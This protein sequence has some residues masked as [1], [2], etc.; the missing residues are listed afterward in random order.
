M[1]LIV[2]IGS[3]KKTMGEMTTGEEEV[4]FIAE[5]VMDADKLDTFHPGWGAKGAALAAEAGDTEPHKVKFAVIRVEEGWSGSKR[6]WDGNELDSIVAQT[7]ALEPVGHLGHIPD[8]QAAFSMPEPQT[9][10]FGAT[11]KTEPSKQKDRMGEMVK[12]AYFAGYNLL[13]ARVRTLIPSRAVRGISWWGKGEQVVI[14]GKGVQVKGFKLLA[15][16]WARK[17]SE[18]MPTSSVVATVR[19]MEDDK[20]DKALSQVTPEEFEKENP[21]GYALLVAKVTADK[22]AKIGEM[23]TKVAEGETAKTLLAKACEMLGIDKPEDIETK[24]T[25][26]RSRVG[27]KAKA[28]LKAGLDAILLEKLPGAENA[29]KRALVAR[30]LPVGE[31]ETKVADTADQA[32]ADKLIGEMVDASIDKDDQIKVVI[33]EQQPPAIRRR[34]ELRGS[35]DEDLKGAGVKRE[36]V[37]L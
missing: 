37:R 33:G 15:L 16:D 1:G 24:I 9:T 17:G 11:V 35:T 28:T 20:M 26:L 34:E 10:W 29:D 27:D 5:Q 32:A 25:E 12:V 31:M 13:G 19:E 7:N 23:E 21:N 30:L 8:D 22:D 6:L 18:G 2:S 36:R 3:D 4:G 14:P